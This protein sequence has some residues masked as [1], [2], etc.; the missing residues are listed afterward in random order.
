[1]IKDGITN[2]CKSIQLKGNVNNGGIVNISSEATLKDIIYGIGGGISE[3]KGFKAVQLGGASG[4]LLN[5]NNLDLTLDNDS[6]K[7]AGF[8]GRLDVIEVIDEST[9]MVELA[10]LSMS[11]IIQ[12]LCGKCIPCREGTKCML[13]ILERITSGAGTKED[14]DI[15]QDLACTIADTSLCR[16]GKVSANPVKSTLKYFKD[17]YMA[18]IV[19]KKCP[20]GICQM[21]ARNRRNSV[22]Y[23]NERTFEYCDN[24][25]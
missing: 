1:M 9:C 25:A 21:D 18:H 4:I 11:T 19:Q 17:E 6:L 5:S 23:V 13:D 24:I 10:R 15:L 3:G 7:R 22:H 20:A 14:I 2:S 8:T 12:G 16:L